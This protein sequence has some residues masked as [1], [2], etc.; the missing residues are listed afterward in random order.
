MVEEF[1]KDEQGDNVLHEDG[2]AQRKMIGALTS[3]I[4]EHWFGSETEILDKN[5]HILMNLK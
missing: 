3:M 2:S 4:L 1:V 5:S